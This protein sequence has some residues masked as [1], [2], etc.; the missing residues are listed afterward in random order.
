MMEPFWT[1][2]GIGLALG[3]PIFLILAGV[4]LVKR[5]ERD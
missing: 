5:S 3:L 4:A 2:L 1:G